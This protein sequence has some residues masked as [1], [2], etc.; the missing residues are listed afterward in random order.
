MSYC[1]P[2]VCA[3]FSKLWE[4]GGLN[5]VAETLSRTEGRNLSCAQRFMTIAQARNLHVCVYNKTPLNRCTAAVPRLCLSHETV[6][7]PL[8][9]FK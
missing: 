1:F 8:Y 2:Y 6:S 5:I 4:A 9:P 3:G 7:N